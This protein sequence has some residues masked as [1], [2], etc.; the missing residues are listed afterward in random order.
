MLPQG[1][2]GLELVSRAKQIDVQVNRITVKNFRN[3][4]SA[5][6]DFS[7]RRNILIGE[8]AQGKTNLLEAIELI[9]V[10]RSDR[11]GS[12]RELIAVGEVETLIEL[13][14][15]AKSMQGM[16]ETVALVISQGER[17]SRK[18]KVNGL[19][20]SGQGRSTGRFLSRL[21]T[22]SF[23]TQD[24]NLVRG[25]PKFRRDWL[26]Q[27]ALKLKP[28]HNDL[29]SKYEKVVMQRNRLLRN[30]FEKGRLSVSDQDEIKV[31]DKQLAYYG[32]LVIKSRVDALE[33]AIPEA[34]NYQ[35]SISG[36]REKLS[37]HYLFR[38]KEVDGDFQSADTLQESQDRP[39]GPV[40]PDGLAGGEVRTTALAA[41]KSLG[42]D[43]IFAMETKDL[44]LIIIKNLRDRRAEEIAR[45]QTLT[46]PHR[47][48][49][50]FVLNGLPATS[51]ASQGQQR[52]LVLALK[53]A[54]LKLVS[55]VLE[56]PPLLLLDDV[57][58]ELDLLRQ[59][60]LMQMVS[61]NM[62]TLITTTHLTSFRPEWLTGAQI[63]EVVGGQLRPACEKPLPT[64]QIT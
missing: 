44:A 50:S 40:E 61:E 22:V 56:E 46:G 10:G 7:P 38:Q 58:A 20:Q 32:A 13:T 24:L 37:C 25:G 14:F 39:G 55:Q 19:T 57:L 5:T 8:N 60:T 54:E 43:E 47:D 12:D 51:Y 63:V 33:S 59:G 34:E 1:V 31:W 52:S 4:K 27:L 18:V 9:S 64:S 6:L 41:D 36:Q 48:D 49:V 28:S 17:L 26:D 21:T 3:Y 11:A 62:Q 16:S 2:F 30:F 35:A 15:E 23:K 42:T 53:L 45:R 29:L